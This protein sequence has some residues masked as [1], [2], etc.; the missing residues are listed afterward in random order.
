MRLYSGSIKKGDSILIQLK[1]KRKESK[2]DEMHSNNREEID[3]AYA[4]DIVALAGMKTPLLVIQC[5][6]VTNQL[7]LKP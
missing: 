1:V 3:S 4:G 7:F 6:I 2:K 5:V